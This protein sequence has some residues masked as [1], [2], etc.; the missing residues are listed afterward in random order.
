MHILLG[1]LVIIVGTLV[2]IKSEWLF[3]NFG[4]IAFFD[5]YFH[6]S[7]G[8]RFGYKMVGIIAII[9]GIFILTNI[10][11]SILLAIAGLFNFS[12]QNV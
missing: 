10:I 8:G 11:N 4:S 5:K 7:G 9:I 2:V 6:S 12:H 1:L 3:N